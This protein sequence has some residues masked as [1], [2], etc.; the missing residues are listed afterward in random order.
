MSNKPDKEN[1][2]AEVASMDGAVADPQLRENLRIVEA[3]LFASDTPVEE[4]AILEHLPEGTELKPI[5]EILQRD[6]VNRGVNCKPVGK[7]WAFRT[8]P[9]LAYLLRREYVEQRKLSRAAIETLAIIA[10]RLKSGLSLSICPRAPRS[11]AVRKAQA[12]PTGLQL[13]PRLT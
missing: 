13:T 10:D 3:L 11:G 5:M 1:A 9:D 2:L 4:R 12:L 6:Y 7:A 8:A